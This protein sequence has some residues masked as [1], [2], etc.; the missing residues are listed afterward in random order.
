MKFFIRGPDKDV[1]Y[2]GIWEKSGCCDLGINGITVQINGADGV[3]PTGGQLSTM[4]SMQSY[5]P[6]VNVTF[7]PNLDVGSK[8]LFLGAAFAIN[9]LVYTPP[10]QHQQASSRGGGGRGVGGILDSA[11]N[12]YEMSAYDHY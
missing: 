3:T 12:E 4:A 9:R 10:R 8:S 7:P 5:A 6:K 2:V 1:L 11:T